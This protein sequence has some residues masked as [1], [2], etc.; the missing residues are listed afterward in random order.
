MR[1]L[2]TEACSSSVP[3][4]GCCRRRAQ[5]DTVAQ[6]LGVSV[7]TLERWRAE[8]L[9]QPEGKRIRTAAARLQA[10]KRRNWKLHFIRQD[11][12]FEPPVKNAVPTI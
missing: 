5:I 11:T 1:W 7:S 9:S 4:H 12:M 3:W 6:E 2:D 8:A 10:V